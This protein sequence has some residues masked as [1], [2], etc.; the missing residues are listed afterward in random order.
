MSGT[1]EVSPTDAIK[2][3]ANSESRKSS[4]SSSFL[5]SELLNSVLRY[6]ESLSTAMYLCP[7]I[8]QT[9]KSNI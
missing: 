5:S 8:Y 7:D 3:I 2:S 4:I 1:S 9:S 6:L